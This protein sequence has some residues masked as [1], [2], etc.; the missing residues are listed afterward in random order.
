ME[1]GDLYRALAR[2]NGSLGR[3]EYPEAVLAN[4]NRFWRYEPTRVSAAPAAPLGALA[5][6]AALR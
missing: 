5:T 1:N 2:Y 4:L 3:P 6:Q